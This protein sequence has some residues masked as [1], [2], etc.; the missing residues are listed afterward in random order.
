LFQTKIPTPLSLKKQQKRQK[1]IQKSEKIKLY[2]VP[3]WLGSENLTQKSSAN[4]C[5]LL[6]ARVEKNLWWLVAGG[7]GFFLSSR[8]LAPPQAIYLAQKN[9][10]KPFGVITRISIAYRIAD[11][12]FT[13]SI[14][15][16]KAENSKSFSLSM[17]V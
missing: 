9:F 16:L 17:F 7:C 1:T 10:H 15:S 12:K 4:N 11:R 13:L 8:S 5:G 14:P 6:A 3:Q 2:M